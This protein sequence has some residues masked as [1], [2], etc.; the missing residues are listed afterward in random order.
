MPRMRLGFFSVRTVRPFYGRRRV[1]RVLEPPPGTA[2]RLGDLYGLLMLSGAELPVLLCTDTDWRG[3]GPDEPDTAPEQK[4]AVKDESRVRVLAQLHSAGCC[5]S[6]RE[7]R[8]RGRTD[9]EQ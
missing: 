2:A 6:A 1:I 5:S 4:P 9:G 7:G 8:Y 3:A